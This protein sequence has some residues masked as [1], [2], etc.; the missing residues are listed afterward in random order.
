MTVEQRK[1]VEQGLVPK[2][3]YLNVLLRVQNAE[4]G[5][6]DALKDAVVRAVEKSLAAGTPA[7][8]L[9]GE[10]KRARVQ[11]QKGEDAPTIDL[12]I[13]PLPLHGT[14]R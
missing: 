2:S 1:P 6:L 3:I 10:I 5:S 11:L 9:K 14:H 8:A 12:L 7:V 4:G 13:L